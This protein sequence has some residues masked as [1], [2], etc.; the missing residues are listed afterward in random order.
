MN[1]PDTKQGN[2]YKV[3][4]ELFNQYKITPDVIEKEVVPDYCINL[5]EKVVAKGYQKF[6]SEYMSEN[7]PYKG[8]LVYHGLG[9]GKTRT[10]VMTMNNNPSRDFIILLPAS[11][12]D[13]PWKK[14]VDKLYKG[15]GNVHYISYNASNFIKQVTKY[16]RIFDNKFIIIEECHLFFQSIISGKASQAV[17]V[18]EL[19]FNSKNCR[20]LCL[21]GTPISG[22]PFELMQMFNLFSG[23]ISKQNKYLLPTTYND[24]VK[25]FVDEEHGT[26]KNELVLK[27]RIMGYV[28][29]YKE[30]KDD[31]QYVVPKNNPIQIINTPLG[32][33]QEVSYIKIRIK[34]GRIEQL[35]KYSTKAFRETLF[36]K[37]TRESKGT[38]KIN[39][40][41]ACTFG[42][43]DKIDKIYDELKAVT[44]SENL[45]K[46]FPTL[47]DIN[48]KLSVSDFKWEIFLRLYEDTIKSI[49]DLRKYSGKLY[50][51]LINITS[52]PK[53]KKF[54][55][56]EYKALGTRLIGY[57]LKKLYGYTE[58]ETEN[59]LKRGT[60]GKRFC[61][62]DGD[63][64]HKEL[65]QKLFNNTKTNVYGEDISILLG[66]KVVAAG[67][68]FLNT[69]EIHILEPQWK[70]IT[71]TQI[72]GRPRRLCSHQQL[73]REERN[74]DTYIYVSTIN[75]EKGKLLPV[76][77]NRETT[78]QILWDLS[79][80][81]EEYINSFLHVLKEA[82]VD[83]RLNLYANQEKDNKIECMS[84]LD[85]V[86]YVVP[87]DYKYH[88]I[89]G[90]QCMKYKQTQTLYDLTIRDGYNKKI[91]KD[92]KKDN[93]N[94]VYK[95][96]GD[97]YEEVGYIKDN[98]I[99]LY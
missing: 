44:Y 53:I 80:K 62:I 20:Y 30:L 24:F 28:S 38:Y 89:E 3:I 54:V 42:F 57:Y 16:P 48:S 59:D 8:L 9:S 82:A 19:L 94:I 6:V 90:S 36:K 2:F 55:Y 43:P 47:R 18:Y 72:I 92:M 68:S 86:E 22:D 79:Q 26:V 97:N 91:H 75:P 63:T 35:Y 17:Q 1:Y 37:P 69:R 40:R 27:E 85:S 60:N 58:V 21:S 13:S 29:Y 12:R 39:S 64:K 15:K 11:L 99:I 70:N 32:S 49:N 98:T 34:E 78:D 74:I 41:M 73:P 52:K 65:I 46:K 84:C 31:Y 50:Q 96:I 81:R 4:E 10:A 23:P 87:D 45:Y 61:I 25:Y 51:I 5:K 71:L 83:C 67:Y 14:T 56:S 33:I 66:T 88:I 76:F 77:D 7:T 95:K 93:N